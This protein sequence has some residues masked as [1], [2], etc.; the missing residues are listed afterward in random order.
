MRMRAL[1]L[2]VLLVLTAAVALYTLNSITPLELAKA[3]LGTF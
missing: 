1:F 3:Q 2:A